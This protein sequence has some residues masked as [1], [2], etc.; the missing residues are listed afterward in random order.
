MDKKWLDEC[1]KSHSNILK[2]LEEAYK[3]KDL[4]LMITN[5]KRLNELTTHYDK[6]IRLHMGRNGILEA[7]NQELEGENRRLRDEAFLQICDSKGR[8]QDAKKQLDE[9]YNL[10]R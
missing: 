1:R 9:F 5:V 8:Y 2:C 10:N 3:A 4:N 6:T 7:E